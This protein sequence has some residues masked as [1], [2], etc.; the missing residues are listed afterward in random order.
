MPVPTLPVAAPT[1]IGRQLFH[2]AVPEEHRAHLDP[3]APV[4]VRAVKSILQHVAENAPDKYRDISHALLRLGSKASVETESSFGLEDLR[5]PVDKVGIQAR[6][7]AEEDAIMGRK[8]LSEKQRQNELIKLYGRMSN[9]MPEPVFQAAVAKGSNLGKMVASGAR[10]SKGQLNS[11]VGA[12]W[13]V[14]DANENFIPVPIKRNYAEGLDPAEYFASAYGTRAGLLSTK[15][16]VRDSGFYAKQLSSAVQD[17]VV[18]KNDCGT[19]RGIPVDADDKD[20]VGALLL[21]DTGGHPAGSPVTSRMM[22]DFRA[23]GV[24][25]LLLRSP[26]TCGAEQG[27]CAACAG[28]RER[29]G[30]PPIMDNVGLGA[31]SALSEPLSQG[32]LSSKHSAGVANAG[33]GSRIGGFEAVNQLGQIP[34]TFQGGAT[35]AKHDGVVHKIEAAPQGGHFVHVDDG[36]PDES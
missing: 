17:L 5:S 16:A 4:D 30:L 8:D 26:V 23:H 1:T 12:D 7:E 27:I 6:A 22:K 9:E 19:T 28:V 36:Q 32:L 2:D 21:R 11:N 14:M 33:K 15:F 31:A 18:T 29:G 34:K 13:L 25:R 20:N 24:K 3:A 10:G 35:A